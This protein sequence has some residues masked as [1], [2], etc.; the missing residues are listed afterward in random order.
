MEQEL[1]RTLR[2]ATEALAR[3]NLPP[4]A[5]LRLINV[6]ENITYL[7]EAPNWRSVLRV[8][9][10]NYNST[11]AI[12]SELEWSTALR[13]TGGVETPAVIN[14]IDTQPIQTVGEGPES[15]RMVMFAFIDGAQ[16]NEYDDLI[17]PFTEL[18]AIAAKTHLHSI[19]WPR[20]QG[21]ERLTWDLTTVFGPKAN[22]GDWRQAPN[23]GPKEREVLEQVETTVKARLT[24]YG[25]STDRY[26]LIHADMRLANLILTDTETR[27]IDF[28]DCGFGWHMYDFA[29][30]ISFMEDH[31]QIPALKA[32]WLTGYQTIR[33][34][35]G[36]DITA[37]EDLIMLRRLALLA[38]IGTHIEAPEPQALAPD[39]ARVSAELGVAYLSQIN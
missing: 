13:Q 14:G 26:G 15:R 9:R 19:A 18:G 33:P 30:A 21:F 35:S 6:S 28:D 2:L 38:W 32:A 7:V 27:L 23:V 8:H 31:P 29:A 36:A 39:F 5:A 10:H 4:G 34:L 20:P 16:P 24:I 3:W 37:I 22:W 11:N 25:Q 17:A 1:S 12:K